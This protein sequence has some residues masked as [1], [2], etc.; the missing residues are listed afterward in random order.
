ML[1]PDFIEQ[2]TWSAFEESR[3]EMK[4]PL[5]EL[6][7]KRVIQKLTAFHCQ[8]YVADE[9]L[10][11]AVERGWRTVFLY[12]DAPRRALTTQEQGNVRQIGAMVSTAIKAVR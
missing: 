8:G 5:G 12:P 11:E 10:G 1:L 3:R 7:R 6:A 9:I 2:E 4:K